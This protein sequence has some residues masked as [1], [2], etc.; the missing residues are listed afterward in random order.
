MKMIINNK[1]KVG[2]YI[3]YLYMDEKYPGRVIEL[4]GDD[5][6]KIEVC[7]NVKDDEYDLEIIECYLHEVKPID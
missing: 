1:L 4:I 5:R 3:D 6:V 7:L 2:D